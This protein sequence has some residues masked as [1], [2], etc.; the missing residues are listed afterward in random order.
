MKVKL[1]NLN[2][3]TE[4][5]V[6]SDYLNT[7]GGLISVSLIV[8]FTIVLIG[9]PICFGISESAETG[10][11]LAWKIYWILIVGILIFM[12]QSAI[13]ISRMIKDYKEGTILLEQSCLRKIK[14]GC[15][16]LYFYFSETSTSEYITKRKLKCFKYEYDSSLEKNEIVIDCLNRIAWIS[17]YYL[18]KNREEDALGS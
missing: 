1:K 4:Q 12:A 14:P 9:L 17:G 7:M 15:F 3:D 10:G 13:M 8:L 16:N 5:E 18:L 11:R 6:I 2:E